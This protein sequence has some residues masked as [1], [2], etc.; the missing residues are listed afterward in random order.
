MVESTA[1]SEGNNGLRQL[2]E[3]KTPN[4]MSDQPKQVRFKTRLIERKLSDT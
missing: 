1:I 4:E 2:I 3:A